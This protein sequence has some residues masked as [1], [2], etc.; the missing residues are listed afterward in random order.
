MKNLFELSVK[1]FALFSLLFVFSCKNNLGKFTA[2]STQ[3]VRGLEYGGK[4][5]D[6]I[7]PVE[8]KSCTHRVYL[9]RTVLGIV[10]GGI[11]WFMPPFDLVFGDKEDD[12]ME[13]AVNKAVKK[14]KNKGVFDGDLLVNSSVYE[15]N[16]IVPLFYGYKCI[17]VEGELVSS[18][19]RKK[20]FLEKK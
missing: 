2:I 5:R 4:N 11:A 13:N 1:L 14:G 18:T 8:E 20:S 12:R 10:T 6:E 19:I 17:G 9:T 3:N 15:K 7:V 16:F